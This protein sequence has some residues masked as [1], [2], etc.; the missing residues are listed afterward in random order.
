MRRRSPRLLET[1][2]ATRTEDADVRDIALRALAR[3]GDSRSVQPLVAALEAADAWLAPHLADILVRHGEAAIDPL[4]ALLDRPAPARARAWAANV[5]GELRAAP[6]LPRCS[7]DSTIRTVRFAPRAPRPSDGWA[8]E[9]PWV[10]CSTICLPIL[11]HSC[12]PASP[13]RWASSA[14][15]MSPTG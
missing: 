11:P 9:A 13:A 15:P 4:L 6:P 10:R 7:A 3:I 1:V 8:N 2:S 14:M 12:A 5:L